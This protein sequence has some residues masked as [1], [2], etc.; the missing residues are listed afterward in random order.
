MDF[1]K[2]LIEYQ[3]TLSALGRPMSCVVDACSTR[4]PT[5]VRTAK[6]TAGLLM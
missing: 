3:E 1:K 2:H 5:V 6:E 4:V